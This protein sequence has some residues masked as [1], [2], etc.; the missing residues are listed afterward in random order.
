MSNPVVI[1]VQKAGST[2]GGYIYYCTELKISKKKL[3]G[4]T[5]RTINVLCNFFALFLFEFCSLIFQNQ[6]CKRISI[7]T[8]QNNFC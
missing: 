1:F 3:A 2:L 8:M 7:E 5:K 6:V 4:K